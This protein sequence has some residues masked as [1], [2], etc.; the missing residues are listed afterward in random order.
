MFSLKRP[1]NG[2][3]V[4]HVSQDIKQIQLKNQNNI[5]I[6][7]NLKSDKG[8]RICSE[9]HKHIS[10]VWKKEEMSEECKKSVTAHIYNKAM[11]V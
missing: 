2:L 8:I 1:I 7:L 6:Q 4:K 9:I 11:Y 3:S 10:F 5:S